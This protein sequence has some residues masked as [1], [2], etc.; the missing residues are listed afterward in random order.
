MKWVGILNV[1]NHAKVGVLKVIGKRE[2]VKGWSMSFAG[3]VYFN[4]R[5]DRNERIYKLSNSNTINKIRVG[6]F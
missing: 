3:G 6:N 5:I 4:C 2:R 1:A